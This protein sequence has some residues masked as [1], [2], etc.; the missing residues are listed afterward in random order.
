MLKKDNRYRI[1]ELFFE[2]PLPVG[3]FQLREI[4]R[5]AVLGA[6]SVKIYLE[7]LVEEGLVLKKSHRV[8]GY[9]VYIANR[10]NEY[11]RFLK[12]INMVTLLKESGL[13]DY[14][15]KRCTP[16][17]IV[18]FGSAS[19]GE[20]LRESDVDIFVLSAEKA[21]ELN[22]YEKKIKRKINLFFSHSFNKL[23]DELKNN[24]INGTILKGYITIF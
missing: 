17:A 12:R 23:S 24:I 22:E 3:G 2:D 14:L 11:F 15:D 13:I 6:P 19:R 4:C 10:D 7:D 9:P 20:D 8:Q 18:L 16:G 5:K 21:V 1:L